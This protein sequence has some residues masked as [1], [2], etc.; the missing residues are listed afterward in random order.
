MLG[1][2]ADGERLSSCVSIGIVAPLNCITRLFFGGAGTKLKKGGKN[3]NRA[4]FE[5]VLTDLA[6]AM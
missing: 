1:G 6:S 3:P 2:C 5:L 4:Y